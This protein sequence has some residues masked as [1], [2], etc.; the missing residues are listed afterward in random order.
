MLFFFCQ[1]ERIVHELSHRTHNPRGHNQRTVV[2]SRILGCLRSGPTHLQMKTVVKKTC[3]RHTSGV[4]T[5][6]IIQLM[7]AARQPAPKIAGCTFEGTCCGESPR[8]AAKDSPS[9]SRRPSSGPALEEG[10]QELHW[11]GF[12]QGLTTPCVV[13]AADAAVNSPVIPCDHHDGANLLHKFEELKCTSVEE[14]QREAALCMKL[15]GS[16]LP[17][18]SI[19]QRRP[20]DLKCTAITMT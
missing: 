20:N 8:D 18:A 9:Y 13:Q 15:H 17:P 19:P 12:C 4:S 5:P 3:K 11:P 10:Q 14:D 6:C 2:R 1:H 16:A 7:N